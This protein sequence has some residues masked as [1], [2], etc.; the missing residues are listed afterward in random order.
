[1]YTRGRHRR[2][3]TYPVRG[4]GVLS[5]RPPMVVVTVTVRPTQSGVRESFTYAGHHLLQCTGRSPGVFRTRPGPWLSTSP[6]R[7]P[8]TYRVNL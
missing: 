4:P 6:K 2:H 7:G 3:L 1:M 8:G 5:I